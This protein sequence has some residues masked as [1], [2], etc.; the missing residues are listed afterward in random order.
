MPYEDETEIVVMYLQ[1]NECQE[2]TRRQEEGMGKIF[3]QS[4]KK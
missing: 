4:L 3:P 1:A 2:T